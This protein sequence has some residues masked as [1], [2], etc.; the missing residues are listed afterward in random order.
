MNYIGL[1]GLG[2]MG[3]SLAL[4]IARHGYT[5]SVW[6]ID[7]D[8]TEKFL[9]NRVKE[10]PVTGCYDLKEFV[11]SLEKPRKILLMITAGKAVD[12]VTES[13]LPYLEEGDTIA[14]LG[15]SYFKDTIRRSEELT[16]K[17][18]HFFGVGVSGGEMGAL[19]GP[20]I[21]PG[22]N[23]E[24]YE[25][26][27]GRVLEDIS[28][29]TKDG[30]PCCDYIGSDGAGHY[31]KMV[32]NGIEYGDIQIICE[33]YDIMKNVLAMDNEEMADVFT[34]WN[35]GRLNSYLIE[36]TS[37]ILRR[38]DEE[39][40]KYI[41]DVI[42]D[43]AGQKGTG[44]WTSLEA[45]DLGV[46]SSTIAES[47]FARCLTALKEQRVK[48][49]KRF[50]KEKKAF[51]GD[52]EAFLQDLEA[53]VYASKIVSY[54]QGFAQLKEASKVYHWD[55]QFGRIALLWREGCIIRAQFLEKIDEVFKEDKDIDNLLMSPSFGKEVE[56]AL[57]SWRSVVMNA[58][59][60]E[61]YIPT[62]ANSL[63]YF[64]GYRSER[65][66]A[67]LLQAQRD[68]FG[69][70]TYHRVDRPHDESFHTI[71]EEE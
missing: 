35:E 28:A 16:K 41:V 32:H 57:P 23:K 49:A 9:K 60:H 69:A 14:D 61:L 56:E 62:L 40:G 53:A 47:V 4:N 52:K 66:P 65:L 17:G 11:D 34:K 1:I 33:A 15:N 64:D 19:L 7:T 70:H 50:P 8:V 3:Q 54:A 6:N 63:L 59:A 45:L 48:A 5:T 68:W 36:I 25:N 55:L 2:V 58:I 38:K 31:V 27:L 26:Y 13:L 39:T 24:F 21:M 37:K 42:L 71:W 44:K 20:S 10:E 43:E 18:I 12:S 46:P 29:H 67:N 30:T 51:M 22:G